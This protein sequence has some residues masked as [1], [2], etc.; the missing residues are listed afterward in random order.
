M[1]LESKLEK[2]LNSQLQENK[3]VQKEFSILEN[4]AVIYKLTGP[5]LVKQEKS[6]AILNVE[7][8][9]EYIETEIKRLETQIK[10]HNKTLEE[11]K[12]DITKLQNQL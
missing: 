5:V 12:L 2:K 1:S 3:L 11:Q 10:K 6:E 8:R 9:L 4:E 7:K